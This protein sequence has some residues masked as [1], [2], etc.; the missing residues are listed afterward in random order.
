M[1][2][3]VSISVVIAAHNEEDVI[4]RCLDALL[5]AAQPTELEIVVVC[6]GCT[7]R[8]A[9]RR[10]GI[11]RPQSMWS[12]RP[13]PPRRLRSTSAMP[14]SSGFPRFYVDADVM[15]PLASVTS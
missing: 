9:R 5:E 1:S 11:R 3:C 6:N 4:G 12:K 10:A 15:L 13:E 14:A 2:T 7:D 8:T